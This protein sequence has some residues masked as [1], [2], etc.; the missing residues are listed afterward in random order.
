MIPRVINNIP[1]L[2]EIGEISGIGLIIAGS[3][4]LS[5]VGEF[6][7]FMENKILAPPVVLIVVGVIVFLVASLGCYG[8]IKESYFMLMAWHHNT[9]PANIQICMKV[10]VQEVASSPSGRSS[11][12][13]LLIIF[14]LEF[15][16]GIAAATYK[17]EFRMTLSEIMTNS[18]RNYNTSKSDKIAWDNVQTK[19]ECCGVTGP[20]DWPVKPL[21]C[22]HPLREKAPFPSRD[23]CQNAKP[24]DDFLYNYGCFD[25]LQMRA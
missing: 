4:V 7:H 23:Q 22:C 3:L 9:F 18:L 17:N 5:D 19:L 2:V 11:P 12:F 20:K 15:A 16:V 24:G 14:I 21:S 1:K 6:S 25:E 8:A 13:C 10:F